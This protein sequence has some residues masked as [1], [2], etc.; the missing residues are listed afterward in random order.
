MFDPSLGVLVTNH[1]GHASIRCEGTVL[2]DGGL[3]LSFGCSGVVLRAPL[4]NVDATTQ[5]TQIIP[6]SI[7]RVEGPNGFGTS[8][9]QV[10]SII[11]TEAETRS[12]IKAAEAIAG[13][14]ILRV[15]LTPVPPIDRTDGYVYSSS[16]FYAADSR[17]N[18]KDRGGKMDRGSSFIRDGAP[19]SDHQADV[20]E[21]RSPSV[22]P[23]GDVDPRILASISSPPRRLPWTV[24][25]HDFGP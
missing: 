25:A 2:S 8:T 6:W 14:F 13:A 1:G 23:N 11:G 15:S 12:V 10:A 21:D 19:G 3:T 18:E 5:Q 24:D 22:D 9:P 20:A 16:G 17:G 4:P 7:D